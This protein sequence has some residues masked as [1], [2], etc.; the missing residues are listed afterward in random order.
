M[1]PEGLGPH[2]EAAG[3]LLRHAEHPAQ[4]SHW[5]RRPS[6]GRPPHSAQGL[7]LS[8][9]PHALQTED[10]SGEPEEK[11]TDITRSHQGWY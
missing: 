6:S 5:V 2:L 3:F 10:L 9:T 8:S 4:P 11:S 7:N 1:S